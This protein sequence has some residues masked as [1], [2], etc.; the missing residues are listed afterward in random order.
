MRIVLCLVL[1][2][3]L[4]VRCSSDDGQDLPLQVRAAFAGS[5]S[6]SLDG[7]TE[8]IPI[9]RN[10]TLTFST[11][12]DGATLEEGIILIAN[13]AEVAS[14]RRLGSGNTSVNIST[15]GPLADNQ[16]YEI[17]ITNALRSSAGSQAAPATIRFKTRANSLEILSVTVDEEDITSV[18]R[19]QNIP[20]SFSMNI[21]FSTPINPTTF[22]QAFSLPGTSTTT[23]FTNDDR[24]VEITTNS[25][26][27][28]LRKYTLE[29]S[30]E[31]ESAEGGS[32]DGYTLPFYTQ[33]DS[34]YK[35]PELSDSE[36]L[37]K[38]QEQTF[39]YFWDFGHPVSGLARERDSSGDLVTIG[40]SGFGVMTIPV[41]IERGFITREEGVDRIEKIVNFLGSADRFHGV[42]PHWMNGNTGVTI[43]FSADDD[44]ADLVET[45]FMIQGLLTVRQYLSTSNGKELSIR[46]KITDLWEAVEWDWFTQGGQDVLYWHW[47]P[48]FGWDK[49]LKISGWNESLIIYVLAASSPTHPIDTEV[50]HNGWARNGGM[51][52]GN[53]FYGIELPLGSDRGGPL[54]FSHYSF[55]GLDPR[56]LTDQYA[57]Y[58]EQ[59]V[60]HSAINRSYCIQNPLNYVGYSS[61][62]WGLT[63]SD[64]DEGYSAHSPN[65]DRGVITPTAAVS[66]LPYVPDESMESI[67]FFY[68]VLGDKIWGEY[69]FYDAFNMTENWYANSYLA[70]DQGPIVVMIENHRSA[71]LWD[72]FM[73][74]SDVTGGLDRLG[75]TYD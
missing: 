41:G 48:N 23:A 15:I 16:E 67:R 54:F 50:Y 18:Q 27:Q 56:N 60:A 70:I 51:Q 37:T 47:S 4:F 53:T 6:L 39:R 5:I 17:E 34:S 59:N 14:T 61:C 31:L 8:G 26:L 35:F 38:V 19:V 45:A 36:L 58:W 42:W 68:Y 69:G 12:V 74:D 28:Y 22:D 62:I 46:N 55:L 32:F 13:A 43:P 9:D 2:G 30:D 52:N 20:V 1:F 24:Q 49:N 11:T 73:M 66:A 65:N 64:N 71:L 10:I 75:F 57:D 25:P 63:A 7:L 72:L 44:G 21:L 3:T 40:G 29:I 33:I